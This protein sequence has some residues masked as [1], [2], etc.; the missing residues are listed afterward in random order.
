MAK[1]PQRKPLVS[2]NENNL[3]VSMQQTDESQKPPV[4]KIEKIGRAG[5]IEFVRLGLH[6]MKP[7]CVLVQALD[8]QWMSRALAPE[9]FKAGQ[10]VWS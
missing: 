2:S 10:V 6:E 4:N 8:N 9:A 3:P 1:P 7:I 5:N